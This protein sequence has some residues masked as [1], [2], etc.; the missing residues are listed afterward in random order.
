MKAREETQIL[1]EIIKPLA[2]PNQTSSILKINAQGYAG[3]NN[4]SAALLSS[5]QMQTLLESP[6]EIKEGNDIHTMIDL[7]DVNGALYDSARCLLLPNS[8]AETIVKSLLKSG[9]IVASR[10]SYTP[11]TVEGTEA[12]PTMM[13]KYAIYKVSPIIAKLLEEF[14]ILKYNFQRIIN[15]FKLTPLTYATAQEILKEDQTLTKEFNKMEQS[16]SFKLPLSFGV[17][18]HTSANNVTS[19]ESTLTTYFT[20]NVKKSMKSLGIKSLKRKKKK[21]TEPI[22]TSSAQ[23]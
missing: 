19:N 4:D 21:H 13:T 14:V 2:T 18:Y 11:H 15:Y 17:R 20:K 5:E 12:K 8:F 23:E 6:I 1:E 9:N 16:S 3:A 7:K 10:I 22:A